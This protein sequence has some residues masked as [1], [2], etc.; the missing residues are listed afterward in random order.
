M[1]VSGPITPPIIGDFASLAMV[2]AGAAY[3]LPSLIALGRHHERWRTVTTC[4]LLFGW[5]LVGWAIC[6][7]LSLRPTRPGVTPDRGRVLV[8]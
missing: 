4:N 1:F 8:P 5:T 3:A 6:L 7:V 2:L